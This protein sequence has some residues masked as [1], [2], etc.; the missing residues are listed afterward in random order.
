MEFT[1]TPFIGYRAKP[2]YRSGNL[3]ILSENPARPDNYVLSSLY[4]TPHLPSHMAA[5]KN[6]SQANQF[7]GQ[8]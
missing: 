6:A 7:P 3:S 8:H 1:E 2:M 5:F 4:A